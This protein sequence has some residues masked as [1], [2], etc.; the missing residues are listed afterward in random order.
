MTGCADVLASSALFSHL[1]DESGMLLTG[2]EKA[3]SSL[4]TMDVEVDQLMEIE[5]VVMGVIS[6][7]GG[8]SLLLTG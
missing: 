3:V 2:H 7:M 5:N 4:L 8:G 1:S 6:M